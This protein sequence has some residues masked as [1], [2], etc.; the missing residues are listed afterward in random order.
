MLQGPTFNCPAVGELLRLCKSRA[1]MMAARFPVSGYTRL[2]SPRRRAN[3]CHA[4][5]IERAQAVF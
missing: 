2:R 4:R 3:D 5:V 1:K